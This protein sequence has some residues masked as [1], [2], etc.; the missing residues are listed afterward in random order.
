MKSSLAE[1]STLGNNP[2]QDSLRFRDPMSAWGGIAQADSSER[3]WG[4]SQMVIFI[5]PSLTHSNR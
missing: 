4:H 3:R 5:L 2:K 1:R